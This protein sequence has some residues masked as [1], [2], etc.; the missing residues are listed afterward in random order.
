[1]RKKSTDNSRK[2]EITLEVLKGIGIVGL[3]LSSMV[4]PGVAILGKLFEEETGY[5]G[6]RYRRAFHDLRR[7]GSI[8]V[9]R[10]KQKL[11]L[12][13]TDKGIKRL[14]KLSIHALN[15]KK[16]KSWD[17]KWRMVMFDVPE[18]MRWSRNQIRNIL[19]RLRFEAIQ[20]SVFIHPYPCEDTINFLRTYYK[21]RPGE[22]Y[23]FEAKVLEGENVLREHFKL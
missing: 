19:K 22:F 18:Q 6:R 3:A 17:G 12:I 16:P 5:K 10:Q 15:I 8:R 4:F 14:S 20:K 11:K 23:I 21:L 7:E 9:V 2:K 1:M 13:L